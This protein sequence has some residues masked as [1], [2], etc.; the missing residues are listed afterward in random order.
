MG[1]HLDTPRRVRQITRSNELA[2]LRRLWRTVCILVSS[3]RTFLAAYQDQRNPRSRRC[4]RRRMKAS[5]GLEE[6]MPARTTIRAFV[7]VLVVCALIVP[8]ART[9][10]NPGSA[11]IARF[12]AST[13]MNMLRRAAVRSAFSARTAGQINRVVD[14]IENAVTILHLVEEWGGSEYE[15]RSARRSTHENARHLAECP[16]CSSVLAL[17]IGPLPRI[18]TVSRPSRPT[19]A[20]TILPRR[21]APSAATPKTRHV[22]RTLGRTRG[23]ARAV[24]RTGVAS[25][26]RAT[27]ARGV[28]R[29]PAQTPRLGREARSRRAG[30]SRTRSRTTR[31]RSRVGG[32]DRRSDARVFRAP[33]TARGTG[34][35][36]RSLERTGTVRRHTPATRSTRSRVTRLTPPP[37]TNRAN[38]TNRR[39]IRP[40]A[41][42]F[43]AGQ[44]T[45]GSRQRVR[46]P[47]RN[48]ATPR[49][50]GSVTGSSRAPNRD[51][52]GVSR[53]APRSRRSSPIRNRARSANV[54]R[55]R[56]RPQ[57]GV[58]SGTRA[59]SR[60]R[61]SVTR[62]APRS[63]RGSARA[64]GSSRGSSQSTGRA[65]SG[66]SRSGVGARRRN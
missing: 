2:C 43:G 16:V 19:R 8:V 40:Q 59:P 34:A 31:D 3:I 51:R 12:A 45:T 63:R 21:R 30:V 52:S 13:L 14:L 42:T 49:S 57:R 32:T 35:R 47:N 33:G 46:S 37:R 66:G 53:T 56:P 54:N 22:S 39:G 36:G 6:N 50:Q 28:Q 58:T 29:T 48:R 20:R 62:T 18:A 38:R 65:R 27:L 60:S 11:V 9:E 25:P 55:A 61:S 7:V 41:R 1:I 10:A 44:Q 64:T 24:P 4:G 15:G 5:S 26:T 17:I 23:N